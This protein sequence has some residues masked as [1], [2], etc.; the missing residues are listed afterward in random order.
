MPF[1][2]YFAF[3]LRFPSPWRSIYNPRFRHA[4]ARRIRRW[5]VWSAG[6]RPPIPTSANDN[7]TVVFYVALF[8]TILMQPLV[9]SI[10]VQAMDGR[11]Y[12]SAPHTKG[13]VRNV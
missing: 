12:R 11:R 1:L 7:V 2:G 5:R 10:P 3:W 13:D 8:D 4:A 6:K 9:L